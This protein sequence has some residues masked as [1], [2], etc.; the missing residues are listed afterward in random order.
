MAGCRVDPIK[1]FYVNI[2]RVHRGYEYWYHLFQ[3]TLA[4]AIRWW[5]KR[6]TVN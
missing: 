4:V 2:A 1:G 6:K 3:W 5:F